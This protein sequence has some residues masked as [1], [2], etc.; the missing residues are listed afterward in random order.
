VSL[1][2][3]QA[4]APGRDRP[5]PGGAD[6]PGLASRRD[7]VSAVAAALVTSGLAIA[8]WA[9]LVSTQDWASR[10]R[11]ATCLDTHCFCEAVNP[12][13][14]LQPANT[15]SSLVYVGLGAWALARVV[16]GSGFGASPSRVLVPGAAVVTCAVGLSSAFFHANL[17]FLGQY[18]D[19]LSMYVLGALIVSGALWRG[20]FVPERGALA[21]FLATTMALGVAQYLEPELR[22]VMFA[23]VLV[24]GIALEHLTGVHGPAASP[25][26]LRPLRAGVILLV[27]AYAFWL[28]DQWQVLCWPESWFQGHAVWHTLTA[29]AAVLLVSH[30]ARLPGA[31][32]R[33]TPNENP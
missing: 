19:V 22:R 1:P 3:E 32:R 5:Q 18:L 21:V 27:V 20:G 15:L 17:T 30:Y 7:R 4:S 29:V 10:A 24:P 9:L 28:L 16:R 6:G 2:P 33:G 23:L 25:A 8:L 12:G 26:A 14:M 31:R 13:A 11:P